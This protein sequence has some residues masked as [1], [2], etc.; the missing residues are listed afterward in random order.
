MKR[1]LLIPFVFILCLFVY[2]PTTYAEN[3]QGHILIGYAW[4]RDSN[5][6]THTAETINNLRERMQERF[7]GYTDICDVQEDFDI[8]RD[9]DN[10]DL[11]RFCED[12]GIDYLIVQ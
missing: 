7:S 9:I 6:P 11:G 8:V 12:V 3:S 2:L 1:L 5:T 10:V 4:W